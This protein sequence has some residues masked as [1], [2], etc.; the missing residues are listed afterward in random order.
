MHVTWTI[1]PAHKPPSQCP[2]S[3]SIIPSRAS[4]A[5]PQ[6]RRGLRERRQ[7][8]AARVGQGGDGLG[9]VGGDAAEPD[10]PADVVADDDGAAGRAVV[11]PA[12]ARHGEV[13]ERDVLA[14]GVRVGAARQRGHHPPVLAR[15]VAR[16]VLKHHVGHVDLRRVGRALGCL[17]LEGGAKRQRGFLL[18]GGVWTRLDWGPQDSHRSNRSRDTPRTRYPRARSF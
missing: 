17:D 5:A 12:R 6:P 16:E 18:G 15:R 9:A 7:R 13:P 8:H 3:S 10:V 2:S 4:T 11:V 1:T 14:H